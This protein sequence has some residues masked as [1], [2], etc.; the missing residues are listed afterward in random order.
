MSGNMRV[1]DLQKVV[2]FPFEV[3]INSIPDTYT[4]LR[5]RLDVQNLPNRF[6]DLVDKIKD[7]CDLHDELDLVGIQGGV[8][9]I[10]LKNMDVKDLV[11]TSIT[12]DWIVYVAWEK[13]LQ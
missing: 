1:R 6:T 11:I 3:R 9:E 10:R 5:D 13:N 7:Y 4:V 8:P 12:S 2:D